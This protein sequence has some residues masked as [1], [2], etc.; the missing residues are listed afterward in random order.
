MPVVSWQGPTFGRRTSRFVLHVTKRNCSTTRESSD[1]FSR[2]ANRLAGPMPAAPG[3]A[4]PETSGA[5]LA[6]TEAEL[7]GLVPAVAT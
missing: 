5:R 1:G 6:P 7:A 4:S 3:V 2:Q